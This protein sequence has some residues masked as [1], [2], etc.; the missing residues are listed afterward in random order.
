MSENNNTP[1]TEQSIE[2]TQIPIIRMRVNAATETTQ[3]PVD[4]NLETEGAAADAAATGAALAAK[5]DKTDLD[6]VTVDGKGFETGTRNIPVYGDDIPI[7]GETGADSV[8]DAVSAAMART[9]MTIP[10]TGDTGASSIKDTIDAMRNS[11]SGDQIPITGATGAGSIS[12]AVGNAVSVNEQSFTAAQQAQART[13]IGAPG[14]TEA[15]LV[16]AQT[17]TTSQQAQARTNIGA[18]GVNDAVSVNAQTLTT[19]QQ[20]QARANIAALGASDVAD[21]VRT[22]EQS[23]TTAQQ[24]QA[25]TNIDA[26][27]SDILTGILKTSSHSYTFPSD[28]QPNGTA[29]VTQ[30]ELNVEPIDGYTL[31]GVIQYSIENKALSLTASA[32]SAGGNAYFTVTNRTASA[33]GYN[34]KFNVVLLWCKNGTQA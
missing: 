3:S 11:L 24:T 29:E 18:L 26:A 13:N 27:K 33:A 5:A 1:T 10:I 12:N 31:L 20:A 22:S 6:A 19:S 34:T 9:G 23:L 21:V 2:S 32:T 7:T 16:D 25:R 14:K 8:Y 17:L 15:V 4:A 28:V 30:T